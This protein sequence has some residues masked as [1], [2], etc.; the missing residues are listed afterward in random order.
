[1][2]C[3]RLALALTLAL[4]LTSPSRAEDSA[5][6]DGVSAKGEWRQWRGPHRAEK[7][8]ETGLLKDWE[9]KKPEL[10]WMA[11]GMGSGFASVSVA[12]GKVYTMGNKGNSQTVVAVN[13]AD[14]KVLWE[15]QVTDAKPKHDYEGARCTPAVDGD[16]LYVIS[17]NGGIHCLNKDSGELV[18]SK[19]FAKEWKGFMMSGWGFSESPLVDG[20]LVLCTPG[21]N[22]AV[23]VALNKQTG[24]EVWRAKMPKIGDKGKDGA[25]YSSIVISNGAGVKQYVQLVGRGVI[26]VRASDGKF[27]WGYNPVANGVANIPTP[28][29]KDDYVFCSTGYGTG[30]ALLQ[31]SKEGD[32]VKAEEKYFLDAKTL[33]NHHG[34]MV[35]LDGHVY[36]GHAHNEGFP[37]CVELE[38]GKVVWG[39]KRGAG[40]GSAGVTYADGNF[41]FRYQSG[42]VA[43]VGATTEGYQL[44]GTFKPAH[45]QGPSWA[46]PVVAGGRLYIRNMQRLTAYDIESKSP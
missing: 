16:R 38:T 18:W 39:G 19:D 5:K 36:C 7:S 45:I 34:G 23:I 22:D 32:G 12:G 30:S 11:E 28:L 25:G 1:M 10:V 2:P 20:D 4:T 15:T 31:L 3:G 46:H 21:A 33:Q 29:I 44:K 6:L 13:A 8:P 35:L 41:I 40:K 42:D 43:L 24:E 37:I 26:S 27:L 17:S 9:A 14:G